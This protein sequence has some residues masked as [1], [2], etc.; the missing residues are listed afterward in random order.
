MIKKL[1]KGRIVDSPS[2]D[3][4]NHIITPKGDKGPA[5]QLY[6][7]QHERQKGISIKGLNWTKSKTS[8]TSKSTADSQSIETKV[9]DSY[10]SPQ[11]VLL[12]IQLALRDENSSTFPPFPD[13]Q[14][15][16]SIALE[17]Y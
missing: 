10:Y 7:K 9:A 12:N 3:H 16:S 4:I 11:K 1:S 13:N 15:I 17:C 8:L 14:R 5:Q 2:I 6:I